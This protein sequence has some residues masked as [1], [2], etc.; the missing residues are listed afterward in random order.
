MFTFYMHA[1]K[2]AKKEKKKM[3]KIQNFLHFNYHERT[4]QGFS[5]DKCKKTT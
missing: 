2:K 3:K 5:F 1:A 4:Q